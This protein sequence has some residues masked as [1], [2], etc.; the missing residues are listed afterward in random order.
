MQM[1]IFLVIP[2]RYVYGFTANLNSWSDEY[3]LSQFQMI[4]LDMLI[5][6]ILFFFKLKMYLHFISFLKI[7]MA[8]AGY[9]RD[10]GR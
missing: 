8:Q 6:F 10:H 9:I 5:L 1:L 3:N 7:K 2:F 4:T